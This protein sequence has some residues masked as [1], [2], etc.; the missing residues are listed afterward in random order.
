MTEAEKAER[1]YG[2]GEVARVLVNVVQ[3]STGVV[4]SRECG[5]CWENRN[6][7]GSGKHMESMVC[8]KGMEGQNKR[9]ITKGDISNRKKRRKIAV[10]TVAWPAQYAR[11]E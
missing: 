1:R 3:I 4:T 5:G 7:Q 6:A 8:R 10:V 9:P 2:T 11:E